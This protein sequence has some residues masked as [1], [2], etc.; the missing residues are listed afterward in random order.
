M[1]KV[2]V[3][4]TITLLEPHTSP[5][6]RDVTLRC[7]LS[8]HFKRKSVCVPIDPENVGKPV[9]TVVEGSVHRRAIPV[10]ETAMLAFQGLAT[11]L[12]DNDIPCTVSVGT[13]HLTIGSMVYH[14]FERDGAYVKRVPLIMHTVGNYE[15]GLLEISIKKRDHL[16]I[17]SAISFSPCPINANSAGQSLVQYLEKIQR[18]VRSIPNAFPGTDRMYMPL[19]LSEAGTQ[20]L[21]G[22]V[23]LPISSYLMLGGLS[24]DYFVYANAFEVTCRRAGRKPHDWPKWSLQ[25]KAIAMMEMLVYPVQ[26]APY[27]ADL[28]DRNDVSVSPNSV[29]MRKVQGKEEFGEFFLNQTDP[30]TG[31]PKANRGVDCEDT[32]LGIVENTEAFQDH[33]FGPDVQAK[34]QYALYFQEMQKILAGYFIILSLDAI[35]GQQVSDMTRNDVVGGAHCQPNAIPVHFA[36]EAFERTATMAMAGHIGAPISVGTAALP[37]DMDNMGYGLPVLILEG[38]GQLKVWSGPDDREQIRRYV[39]QAPSLSG[40]KTPIYHEDRRMDARIGKEVDV[41]S[42]FYLAALSGVTS[43][44]KRRGRPDIGAL[45]YVNEKGER[46]VRFTDLISMRK[47]VG[48]FLEPPMPQPVVDLI[49]EAMQVLV[50]PDPYTLDPSHRHEHV[51][52]PHLDELVKRVDSLK[53]PQGDPKD[54]VSKYLSPF[55]VCKPLTDAV[56]RDMQKLESVSRVAYETEYISDGMMGYRLMFFVT[57]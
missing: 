31:K 42:K 13:T 17:S 44:F 4:L 45:H 32:G 28:I 3:R 52:N 15:K 56:W 38:T 35:R 46:G 16:Q 33:D 41:E 7:F 19:N 54:F 24:V 27:L 20:L 37:W 50:P 34:R 1:E 14:N 51:P 39:Y 11:R 22:N 57:K 55:Q 10:P 30:K 8:G 26:Y 12:N 21:G 18:L 23:A 36:K 25:Q 2:S 29:D 53:R 49:G 6:E 40:M 48:L 9:E 43:Y 47:N 5:L